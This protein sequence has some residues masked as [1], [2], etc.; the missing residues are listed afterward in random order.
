MRM[1]LRLTRRREDPQSQKKKS[2]SST[3]VGRKERGPKG[4]GALRGARGAR[5][6]QAGR[7]PRRRELHLEELLKVQ[8][9]SRRSNLYKVSRD[10]LCDCRQVTAD[11]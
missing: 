10:W 1:I 8:C 11:Y 9:V 7:G 6:A 2:R 5:N 3:L 4:R